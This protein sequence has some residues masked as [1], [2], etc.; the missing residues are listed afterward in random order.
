MCSTPASTRLRFPWIEPSPKSP[1]RTQWPIGVTMQITAGA[2]ARARRT[3]AI[4]RYVPN[5]FS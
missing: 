2:I 4:T 5:R 1:L 3:E